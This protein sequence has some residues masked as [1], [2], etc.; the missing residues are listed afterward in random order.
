MGT[1]S[2]VGKATPVIN[3][4]T[5]NNIQMASQD[6]AKWKQ[7]IDAARSATNPRRRSLYELYESIVLDGHLLSVMN[8]RSM[9]ITNK[10]ITFVDKDGAIDESIKESVTDT[11]WFYDFNKHANTSIPYGHALIELIPEAGI[12]TKAKL[13]PRFNVIPERSF[14]AWSYNNLDVGFDYTL[15]EP[16]ASYLI[17]SGG[18]KDYGLLMSAAQY[19]IYKRGGLGDWAQFCELF[20]LPL[21]IG[22]Y[23][24]FDAETRKLLNESFNSMGGAAHMIIPK[25]ADIEI[26][27]AGSNAGQSG[28]FLDLVKVCNEEMSKIFLGQTMTTDSGSSRSQSETHKETES[29]IFLADMIEREYLLNWSLKPKLEK[30]RYPVTNGRF[31][32]PEV[33]R[34][35]LDKKIEIALKVS[36]KVEIED[37]YWYKTFN[38]P[39]PSGTK[40]AKSDPKKKSLKITKGCNCL[41]YK[42]NITL[43]A[44]PYEGLSDDEKN[45]LQE[46]YEGNRKGYDPATMQITLNKLRNV[47]LKNV[48]AD[49]DYGSQDHLTLTFMELNVNR[50]GFD[51]NL[52]QIYQLNQA[53]RKATNFTDFAK[54]AG[55]ILETYNKHYLATEYNF[56]IAAAQNAANWN[57]F[58]AQK[59]VY[60]FLKYQTIGDSRVRAAHAA[61]NDKVFSI[62]DPQLNGIYPPNGFGC[63]CEMVQVS[64]ADNITTG[65][66]AVGLLG[67]EWDKMVKGGFAVNRGELRTI[68]DLNEAYIKD[69]PD[70]AILK[71]NAITYVDAGLKAFSK[72]GSFNGLDLKEFNAAK[73][74][75]D[76]KSGS[77]V[78]NDR[79]GRYITLDKV[80]FDKLTKSKDAGVYNHLQEV[81]NAPDEIWF[82]YNNTEDSYSYVKFYEG[83]A[84]VVPCNVKK[85]INESSIVDSTFKIDSFFIS[86]KPDNSRKGILIYNK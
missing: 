74:A 43:S 67:E 4:L 6:I 58:K 5:V 32:F 61:L 26:K 7:A 11:P 59:D 21:K 57:R 47:L 42:K 25:G 70:S 72:M 54:Q 34:L 68:F 40:G 79:A 86:D 71:G 83:K 30:L 63:R 29:D 17:E 39:K 33:D 2:R 22:K 3:Q 37:E 15:E 14:L 80:A 1:N 24:P 77:K 23:D 27:D 76:F 10:R 16:Y 51:K 41:E 64:K 65:A 78:F 46:I 36:D 9:A 85:E 52:S 8:K 38:I 53:L 55:G 18:D 12:V 28:I 45:L 56:A 44:N 60:P 35:P 62:D 84:I 69:L 20:G 31:S 81:F 49:V 13:V 48:F 82:N 19:V 75:D 73:A 66:Q 50:F